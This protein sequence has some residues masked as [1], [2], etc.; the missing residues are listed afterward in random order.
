MSAY[1]LIVE[2]GTAL[3][4]QVRRGEVAMPDDDDLADKYL[5]A[6]A[7]MSAAGLGWYEVS[8]WATGP[9]A[10]C[11]HNV[12]YWNG[13]NW[14]GVGPGAHSHVGGVRWWNVKH[15]AAWTGRIAAGE[16]PAHARETLDA[17]TRRV[18]RVLLEVRLR[19][20]LPLDALDAG[21]PGRRARAGGRRAGDPRG[22]G[23]GAHDPRSIAGRRRG[24]GAAA[25]AFSS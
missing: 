12:G 10:Q 13:D 3:A 9:D 8:N 18:E 22:R 7:A 1:A 14:W 17:E 23:A 20:G 16:S 11:R 25:L 6:D 19:S 24:A 5:A 15:P 21:R 2:D 4:R